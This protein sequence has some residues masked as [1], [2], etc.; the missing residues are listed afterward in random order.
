MLRTKELLLIKIK[1]KNS[2]EFIMSH[3]TASYANNIQ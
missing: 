1:E 3:K 2:I